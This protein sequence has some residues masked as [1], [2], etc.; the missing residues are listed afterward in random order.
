MKNCDEIVSCGFHIAVIV[1]QQKQQQ[2]EMCLNFCIISA[3]ILF[4]IWWK[5]IPS[6]CCSSLP[7]EWQWRTG[8]QKVALTTVTQMSINMFI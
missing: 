2:K 4:K 7:E 1:K 8:L 3:L 5:I 6:E